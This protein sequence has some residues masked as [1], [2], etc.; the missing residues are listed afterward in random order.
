[1]G[2]DSELPGIEAHVA[3]GQQ[4]GLALEA[5]GGEVLADGEEIRGATVELG[6]VV[7]HRGENGRFTAGFVELDEVHAR[8][9]GKGRMVR[10]VLGEHLEEAIH[11]VAVVV[12][13]GHL[14]TDLRAVGGDGV[15]ELGSAQAQP[16]LEVALV[17]VEAGAIDQLPHP[18]VYAS[19]RR[20]A[21][22]HLRGLLHKY[23]PYLRLDPGRFP[24]FGFLGGI[25]G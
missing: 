25:A 1:M 16:P 7:D 22:G 8:V 2:A 19:V 15:A 11:A 10:V 18:L 4:R 17:E 24:G 20:D 5:Y 13:P 23:V 21:G 9:A 3:G 12:E 14:L 6:P